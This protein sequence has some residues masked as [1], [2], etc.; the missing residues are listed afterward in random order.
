MFCFGARVSGMEAEDREA[1]WHATGVCV[2]ARSLR[3]HLGEN[4]PAAATGRCSFSSDPLTPA[5]RTAPVVTV[6]PK[7][8]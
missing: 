6:W 8:K 4:L 1:L 2:G 7:S 3:E 5:L